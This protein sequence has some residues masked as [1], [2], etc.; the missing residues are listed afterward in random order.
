MC[1]RRGTYQL[2]GG[3]IVFSRDARM[4][5]PNLERFSLE[6]L[7][8]IGAS[9]KCPQLLIEFDNSPRE[10]FNDEI[11]ENLQKNNNLLEYKV[12]EG[13]HHQH[14]NNCKQVFD[15]ILNFLN[16]VQSKL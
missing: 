11:M 3:G 12:L 1:Y 7:L 4:N 9:V 13:V 2:N 14:L 15:L 10:M 6:D 5:L 16:K 8:D